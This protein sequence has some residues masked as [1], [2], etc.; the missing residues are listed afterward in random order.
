MIPATDATASLQIAGSPAL[1]V[2]VSSSATAGPYTLTFDN[3]VVRPT[4]P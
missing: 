3:F 1:H 4:A 2:H